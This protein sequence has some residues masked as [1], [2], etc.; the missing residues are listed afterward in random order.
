MISSLKY[1]IHFKP[2]WL[3]QVLKIP[4]QKAAIFFLLDIATKGQS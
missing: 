4:P 2:K 3:V 1:T